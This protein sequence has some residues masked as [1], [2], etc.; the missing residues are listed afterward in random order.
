MI[1]TRLVIDNYCLFDGHHEFD[2][3]PRNKYGKT[4]PI[5]LF[6]GKN[7]AGKTT[8][9]DAIRLILYGRRSLGERL[10]QKEYEEILLSRLHRKK[11]GSPR[12]SFA[13]LGLH[14]EHVVSGERHQY[15]VE[16][17]WMEKG[18]SKVDHYFRVERSGK[19]FDVVGP[20]HWEAFV[21]EM[22]PE[23]LSQLF[24]FDGE[25]IKRIADDISGNAAIS[26][27]IQTLLGLDAVTALKS[28]LQNYRLKILKDGNPGEYEKELA[29]LENG[30]VLLGQELVTMDEKIASIR[31]SIAGKIC[32]LG[33]IEKK[34]S[35]RGGGFAD[36]RSVNQRDIK[37]LREKVANLENSLR[38][39]FE[40]YAPFALC[41]KMAKV[42]VSQIEEDSKIATLRTRVLEAESIKS[43]LVR[44]AKE[45][46][47]CPQ[48]F[49]P[50]VEDMVAEY[51]EELG[52]GNG[53]AEVH[54]LSP[55]DAAR[56][57]DAVSI[58]AIADGLR[59]R[60]LVAEL[61][62]TYVTLHR[63]QKDLELAPEAED[64][65]DMV[66]SAGGIN[67]ELGAERSKETE[68][69]NRKA[70]LENKLAGIRREIEHV[71]QRIRL[72]EAE[73]EKLR[74]I[75]LLG[76]ALDSY[77]SRLTKEKIALLQSEVASCFN[78]LARKTDFVKDIRIDPETFAVSVLDRHGRAISKEELS[79]GEKQI[80]AIAV[81]W[82]LARTSGRPLPVV[83]DTPLGRLD[84][85]HRANLIENYFP[86]AGHQV[87]LL[88]TDTEVDQNLFRQLSPA[89][90]HCYHLEYDH[91][92]GRTNEKEE[93]FWR[94]N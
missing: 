88:S 63:A 81:L 3:S 38:S 47:E 19:I 40:G 15:F 14:F 13:K 49:V 27:A 10:S 58:N 59:I 54:R 55:S 86:H 78:R 91:R 75:E 76:P 41:P 26:E 70:E 90:S 93:Y 53:K 72:S 21:S 46:K 43:F 24:F 80:F 29:E 8:I 92:E 20:S 42:M 89:I 23:R 18:E 7:G 2:L 60:E 64:L 62:T 25:R 79:S 32:S 67:Q 51:L 61:E 1:F 6:G 50:V 68:L 65:K 69:L 9:L 52:V 94:G 74:K 87:I 48:N 73:T 84:S 17:S 16:R 37:D 35:D 83:V 31:T 5:V 28:D 11:D 45:S 22:V 56:F 39:G 85:E 44:R 77:K 30:A 12:S 33:N 4:R 34:I 82:G 36:K 66:A 71:S 57:L